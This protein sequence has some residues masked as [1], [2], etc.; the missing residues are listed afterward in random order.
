MGTR[1]ARKAVKH[2]MVAG[3]PEMDGIEKARI[4]GQI[5]R[6]ITSGGRQYYLAAIGRYYYN[7]HQKGFIARFY[8]SDYEPNETNS[9]SVQ[10]GSASFTSLSYESWKDK[11][12]QQKGVG[13]APEGTQ[14]IFAPLRTGCPFFLGD[15]ITGKQRHRVEMV[16]S[17]PKT[18]PSLPVRRSGQ[19]QGNPRGAPQRRS[20]GRPKGTS[21][22]K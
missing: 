9:F 12:S 5:P 3:A 14:T 1:K 19:K 22:V 2:H 16:P 20:L 4:A 17:G 11:V 21:R 6:R 18:P 10:G 8:E 13:K 15:R 7:G